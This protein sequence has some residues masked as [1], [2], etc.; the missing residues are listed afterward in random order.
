MDSIPIG[1]S[2]ETVNDKYIVLI[3]QNL[4]P[5]ET[6]CHNNP[7]QQS[8]LESHNLSM[9]LAQELIYIVYPCIVSIANFVLVSIL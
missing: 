7:C 9:R 2:L 6:S 3:N 5:T 4:V 1:K 8:T